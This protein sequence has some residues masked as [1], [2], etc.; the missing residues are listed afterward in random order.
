VS[1]DQN[2]INLTGR[3]VRDAESR[4]TKS[5]EAICNVAIAVNGYRREDEATFFD[6]V[7]FGKKAAVAQY[8]VKGTRVALNGRLK[9]RRYPK[10]DNTEGVSLEVAVND[11]SFMSPRDGGGGTMRDTSDGPLIEHKRGATPGAGWSS[12][13]SNDTD[14][15]PF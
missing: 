1:A 6:L 11:L 8:L 5:G 4:T 12:D 7:F 9:L 14:N 13:P 15:I 3:C 10:K 2:N